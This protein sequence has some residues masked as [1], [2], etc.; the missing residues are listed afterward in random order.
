MYIIRG[1]FI[2]KNLEEWK[3]VNA[4]TNPSADDDHNNDNKEVREGNIR[5]IFMFVHDFYEVCACSLSLFY[6]K[7]IHYNDAKVYA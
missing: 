3:E 1:L 6:L 5:V 2:L 4:Y 7:Y